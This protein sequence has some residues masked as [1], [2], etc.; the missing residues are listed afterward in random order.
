MIAYIFPPLAGAGTFRSYAFAKHLVN[1][2]WKVAI[3]SADDPEWVAAERDEFPPIPGVE[4]KRIKMGPYSSLDGLTRRFFVPEASHDFPDDRMPWITRVIRHLILKRRLYSDVDVVFTTSYPYSDHMAGLVMKRT[5]GTPWVADFRDP[6]FD[7]AI[8]M[9]RKSNDFKQRTLGLERIV[10]E[11]ADKIVVVAPTM[12]ETMLSRHKGLDESRIEVVTNGYDEEDF[13]DVKPKARNEFTILFIGEQYGSRSPE[14]LLSAYLEFCNLIQESSAVTLR[15][16]GT[17]DAK[18]QR[19]YETFVKENPWA[20]V[21]IE[22]RVSH[23]E[24]ISEMLGADV[25]VYILGD[26][27]SITKS[28]YPGKVFEYLAARKPILGIAPHG[29][30]GEL[31]ER[32]GAGRNFEGSQKSDIASYLR[33]LFQEYLSSGHLKAPPQSDISIFSREHLTAKLDSVLREAMKKHL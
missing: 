27:E 22:N 7:N 25:L 31:V 19:V 28:V 29:Q 16:V 10:L 15:I 1:L 18:I 5:F 4:Q 33:V 13:R 3:I 2:G 21:E 23:G 6:W 9:E 8:F 17:R 26:G 11:S 32:L 24:A 20:R 12:K 14:P 30:T